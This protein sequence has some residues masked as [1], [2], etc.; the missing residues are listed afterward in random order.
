MNWL[1]CFWGVGATAGPF[2]MGMTLADSG[3]WRAGYVVVAVMQFAL[4]IILFVS[5]PLWKK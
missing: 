1:H 2:I 3:S 4:V 5:I